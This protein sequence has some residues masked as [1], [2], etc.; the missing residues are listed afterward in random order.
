MTFITYNKVNTFPAHFIRKSR[1]KKNQVKIKW[2]DFANRKR[3]FHTTTWSDLKWMARKIA[4]IEKSDIY[5]TLLDSGMPKA[6]ADLYLQKL[7]I[8]RNEI[9]SSFSLEDEYPLVDTVDL[10]KYN[11]DG[12]IKKGKN[13]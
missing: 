6:V 7:L 9:V 8:R 10:K 2:N 3:L 5:R 11:V 13:N 1:N 12:F 4:A